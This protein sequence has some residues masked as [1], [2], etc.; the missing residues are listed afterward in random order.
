[1]VKFNKLKNAIP[2]VLKATGRDI[3]IRFV[4]TGDYNENTGSVIESNTD[5]L[6]KALV[7]NIS[8]NEVN[9][10]INENDK[11]ILIAAKDIN[12]IPSTKDKI[13]ID[14]VIHQIIQVDSLEAAGIAITFTLIV[15][16]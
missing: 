12:T 7:D 11:R 15:R 10:L 2:G 13:L 6:V 4:T 1:M 8:K 5:E 16:S 14:N 9:D 3:T